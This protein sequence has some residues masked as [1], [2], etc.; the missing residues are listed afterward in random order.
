MW[1]HRVSFQWTHP[2][3]C[4]TEHRLG[5]SRRKEKWWSDCPEK[6]CPPQEANAR[7]HQQKCPSP[8]SHSEKWGH[9][10]LNRASSKECIPSWG[11]WMWGSHDL[12]ECGV[13]C[14]C[15]AQHRILQMIPQWKVILFQWWCH[16]AGR[17]LICMWNRW[18]VCLLAWQ[19]HPV[20]G[21]SHW[22]RCEMVCHGQDSLASAASPGWMLFDIW[23]SSENCLCHPTLQSAEQDDATVLETDCNRKG[24]RQWKSRAGCNFWASQ[25]PMWRQ[26]SCAKAWAQ[27]ESAS[28][29]ANRFL[30]LP[31]HIWVDSEIIVLQMLKCSV[32]S[33]HVRFPG[34]VK[35]TDVINATVAFFDVAQNF[36]HDF[37]RNI[38]RNS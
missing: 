33:A 5:A 10:P 29:R 36:F 9:T 32:E 8:P 20:E 23:E 18:L 1:F 16:S 22:C 34:F 3:K 11:F 28:D 21:W 6:W 38:R 26:F 14:N 19:L 37:L 24:Q 35:A 25:S 12:C 15:T 2:H 31:I 17:S 30:S 7:A 4:W 13:L 27:W